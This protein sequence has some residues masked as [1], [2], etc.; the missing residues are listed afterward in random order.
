MYVG[1][2]DGVRVWDPNGK[3]LGEIYLGKTSANFQF[4]GKGRM[5]ICAETELYYVELGAEGAAITDYDYSE[6]LD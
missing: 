4:A 5:V 6:I 1:T 2:G 3:P